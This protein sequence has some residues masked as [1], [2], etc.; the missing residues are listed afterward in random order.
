MPA[1]NRIPAVPPRLLWQLGWKPWTLKR[2]ELL[3]NARR[4]HDR[5]PLTLGGLSARPLAARRA[6]YTSSPSAEKGSAMH[7][8]GTQAT[9]VTIPEVGVLLL[10]YPRKHRSGVC[11]RA[12]ACAPPAARPPRRREA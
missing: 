7:T 6:A 9:T 1:R 11:C 2:C 4:R 10:R 5:C 12:A 3:E 8:W